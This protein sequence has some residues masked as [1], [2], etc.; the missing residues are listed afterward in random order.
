MTSSSIPG[1]W[2]FLCWDPSQR[3][4]GSSV[5]SVRWIA[6]GRGQPST[7]EKLPV[8]IFLQLIFTAHTSF[9]KLLQYSSS[10]VRI[11]FKNQ[12]EII[13]TFA[14]QDFFQS[15]IP[16][17]KKAQFTSLLVLNYELL[18]GFLHVLPTVKYDEKPLV[19]H[20]ESTA[21]FFKG[22]HFI[23]SFMT[24]ARTR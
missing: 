8:K 14:K 2:G 9:L 24:W 4:A 16:R 21:T 7:P 13:N 17:A 3:R 5:R 18:P 10:S 19:P 20:K 15:R 6:P 1:L 12:I 22:R 11:S 23:Q